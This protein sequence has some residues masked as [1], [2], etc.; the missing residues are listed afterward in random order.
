MGGLVN[1][2]VLITWLDLIPSSSA[3]TGI[4]VEL[5][6]LVR[7]W[8]PFV[9]LRIPILVFRLSQP[10]PLL[11]HIP[12]YHPIQ[13]SSASSR[14]LLDSGPRPSADGGF[15]VEPSWFWHHF[16][17]FQCI[18]SLRTK[19]GWKIPHLWMNFLFKPPCIRDFQLPCLMTG[20]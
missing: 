17:R 7:C 19:H 2:V 20:G 8:L 12:R 10:I 15:L 11:V 6:F 5:L 14:H 1:V 3:L 13:I 4:F 9:M 18:Y 16:D